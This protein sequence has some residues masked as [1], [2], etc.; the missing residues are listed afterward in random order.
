MLMTQ[1]NAKSERGL[2]RRNMSAS[3]GLRL[4]SD[5]TMP[6]LLLSGPQRLKGSNHQSM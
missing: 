3:S 5:R 1:I 6:P 4:A 2:L